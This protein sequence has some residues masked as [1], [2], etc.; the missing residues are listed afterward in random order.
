MFFEQGAVDVGYELNRK[1]VY[2]MRLVTN[3]VVGAFYGTFN[4]RAMFTVKASKECSGFQIRTLN[5][6]QV[7]SRYTQVSRMLKIKILEN[8]YRN[9]RRPMKRKKTLDMKQMAQNT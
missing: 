8:F 5:W 9:V 4:R 3:L 6:N 7:L 1:T 2:K